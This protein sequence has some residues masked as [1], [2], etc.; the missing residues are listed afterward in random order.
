[1]RVAAKNFKSEGRPK[2][3]STLENSILMSDGRPV[4]L[5]TLLALQMKHIG[6][7]ADKVNV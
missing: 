7:P 2:L 1:M 6:R 4:T 5:N 3:K